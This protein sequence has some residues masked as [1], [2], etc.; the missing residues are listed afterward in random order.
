[1]VLW[2]GN[3]PGNH[4]LPDTEAGTGWFVLRTDFWSLVIIRTADLG[5]DKQASYLEIPKETNPL[6]GNHG[7]A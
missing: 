1:M 4:Q 6:M 3:T 2:C 5:A 7:P